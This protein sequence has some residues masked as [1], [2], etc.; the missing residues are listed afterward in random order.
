M[1][2]AGSL[3]ASRTEEGDVATNRWRRRPLRSSPSPQPVDTGVDS[4]RTAGQGLRP[5]DDPGGRLRPGTL[6]VDC[7]GTA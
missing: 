2:A 6:T 3:V 7:E 5:G 1:L 4:R